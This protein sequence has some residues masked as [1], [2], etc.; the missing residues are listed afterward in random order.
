[1]C[2]C[3]TT[4][5]GDYSGTVCLKPPNWSS[6]DVVA[7]DACIVDE[8]LSLWSLGVITLGSCCGHNQLDGMINVSDESI[9][10]MLEL[11]YETYPNPVHSLY[12]KEY[13]F[14]TKTVGTRGKV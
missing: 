7:I 13:T 9:G 3:T 5:I 10:K 14:Y 6:K 4:K 8:I 11:G 12:G 1:M 2:N